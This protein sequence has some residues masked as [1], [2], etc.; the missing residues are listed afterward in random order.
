MGQSFYGIKH[1]SSPGEA[2]T[3]RVATDPQAGVGSRSAY[4]ATVRRRPTRSPERGQAVT[5]IDRA[6][7]LQEQAEQVLHH[8][9]NEEPAEGL[10][11]L[12]KAGATPSDLAAD[13]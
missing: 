6:A 11:A 4:L 13:L 10:A 12:G 5:A 9:W 7:R 3:E 8:V 1:S 2:D